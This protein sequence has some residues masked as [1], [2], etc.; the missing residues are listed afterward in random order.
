MRNSSPTLRIA[1]TG[2]IACGKT[3]VTD[4][5]K[6]LGAPIF[7]TDIISREL[8]AAGTPL[9]KKLAA[10]FGAEIINEDGTLNRRALRMIVFSDDRALAD[11]NALTH[12]AIMDELLLRVNACGAPYALMVIPLFFEGT[13]QDIADRVLVIDAAEE[14]QLERL[15]RRDGVTEEIARSMIASQVPRSLRRERADDL[16][17]T[18]AGVLADIRAAVLKLNDNYIAI[19]KRISKPAP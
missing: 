8:T 1:V 16:I 11:L 6:E 15:I 18:S 13:H 7:D 10:R 19:S 14:I 2:G 12:P 17:D 5:F 4:Y 9:L 3:V